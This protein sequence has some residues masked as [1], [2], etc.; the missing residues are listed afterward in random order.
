VF[1]RMQDFSGLIYLLKNWRFSLSN[2]LNI[3]YIEKAIIINHN[4]ANFYS[5]SICLFFYF[6]CSIYSSTFNIEKNILPAR[7]L[8]YYMVIFIIII[9]SSTVKYG[10]IYYEF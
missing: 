2:L 1:F 3:S 6:T 4:F 10:F 5:L 7:W 8:F 9:F